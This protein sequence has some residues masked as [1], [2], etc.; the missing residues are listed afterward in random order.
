MV[1]LID[2]FYDDALRKLVSNWLGGLG[3]VV[4][5]IIS[6]ML[7]YWL[8]HRLKSKPVNYPQINPVTEQCGNRA[9][10]LAQQ[11]L[12]V[13]N[14]FGA[15]FTGLLEAEN[16]HTILPEQ[17]QCQTN[18][19]SEQSSLE[20]V[21][22]AF[23]Q[24]RGPRMVIV[25]ADGGMG[26]STLAAKITRCLYER[27]EIELILGDS[28]KNQIFDPVT[29]TA[30][31]QEPA[32]YNSQSCFEKIC[33][34]VGVPYPTG[35][36]A[37]SRALTAIKDKLLD[38]KAIIIVDNLETVED[39]GNLLDGLRNLLNENIRGLV[40]TRQVEGL[41]HNPNQELLVRL[42]PLQAEDSVVK[43]LHWHIEQYC[44]VHSA[45][46][47]L[48]AGLENRHNVRLLLEKSGGVPLL[49]QL[50]ASEVA[51]TSW[52]GLTHIPNRY[53][54]DL[55]NYLYTERWAE[56]GTLNVAGQA[57]REILTFVATEQQRGKQVTVQKLKK[58][59]E[60]KGIA[61]Q[62]NNGLNLLHQRF[63]IVNQDID[64]GNF[65]VFPSLLQFVERARGGANGIS[66]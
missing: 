23:S 43:F 18:A 27:Q 33:T 57:A 1:Q 7:G 48:K 11:R 34:Q 2:Y 5:I 16:I 20:Q 8:T 60:Q 6:F 45:L 17:I 35:A 25:G 59:L 41:T 39:I 37:Y 53:G 13:S 22:W 19:P 54:D 4:M 30:H 10:N 31:A 58:Q 65:V 52:Q 61:E 28:A 50:L 62:T 42:H 63:L 24:P 64:V 46:L 9:I 66:A 55:L 40:T 38:R 47:E 15:Y 21:L 26:K 12:S 36:N 3:L 29:G 44:N 56:L 14:A 51:R 32:I 49:F